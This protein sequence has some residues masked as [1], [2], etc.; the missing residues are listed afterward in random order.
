[1]PF[2]FAAPMS[3]APPPFPPRS[4]PR[5]PGRS[6]CRTVAAIVITLFAAGLFTVGS[7]RPAAAFPTWTNDEL[8]QINSFR[9][10]NGVGPL[11]IC[12]NLMTSAQNHAGDMAAR[13]YFSHTTP[14]GVTF[15]QRITGAGYTGWSTVGENIASGQPSVTAVMTAWIASPGHRANL[16]DSAY[17]DV[18]LGLAYNA[19][20]QPVWVQ[21]FGAGGACGQSILDAFDGVISPGPQ[22]LRVRGWAFDELAPLNT[23]NVDIFVDGANIGRVGANVNRPGFEVPYPEAGPNHGFDVTFNT[24]AGSHAVCAFAVDSSGVDELVGC[25]AIAVADA[26]PVGTLDSATSGTAGSISL[27]G[28]A[29]DPEAQTQIDVHIYL[30]GVMNSILKA[31]LPRNDVG[32]AYPAFGPNRGYATTVTTTTGGFHQVCA[33]GINVLLGNNDLLGCRTLLVANPSPIGN[34]DSVTVGGPRRAIATGWTFDADSP[35]SISVDVYADGV[36]M[37]RFPA[38]LQRNDVAAAFPAAGGLHGYSINLDLAP[39]PHT[40]CSY[41][42]N[43]GVIGTNTTLGCKTLTMPADPTGSFDGVALA[44]TNLVGSGW[45]IDPDTTASINVHV[46]ID[47]VF[48]GA[49]PATGIRNDLALVF[50]FFGAAHGFTFSIPATAGSHNVCVYGIN[51][52]GAGTNALLR[53]IKT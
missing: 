16:V 20:G 49:I 28:W 23:V 3:T 15:D 30:D 32:L 42:I 53:C 17:T 44:G 38:A 11:R 9:A 7:A 50:P 33:Y 21:D 26:S 19:S 18:G 8:A 40:V 22:V 24:S 4:S 5:S 39:G 6:H 43:V 35:G 12:P 13:N 36:K 48:K 41:G 37:G 34:L 31:N 14:E 47:G 10:G 1:M 45:A 29:F 27:Y 25:Q 2:A 46:Y 52:A 51:T